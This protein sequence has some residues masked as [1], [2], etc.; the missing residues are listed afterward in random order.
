MNK[1]LHVN[2]QKDVR[3]TV[4]GTWDPAPTAKTCT[5]VACHGAQDTRS[6][7]PPAP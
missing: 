7:Y 3:L 4:P 2:G 6:W 5:N 1:A